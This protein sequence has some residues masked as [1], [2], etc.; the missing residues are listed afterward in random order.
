MRNSARWKTSWLISRLAAS[1]R[2]SFRPADSSGW[3][4]FLQHGSSGGKRHLGHVAVAG[5]EGRTKETAFLQ[6]D[7]YPVYMQG[8]GKL[9]GDGFKQ[10]IAVEN[11]AHLFAQ[12]TE[13]PFGIIG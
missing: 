2:S 11:G 13:N 10:G 7:G 6:D 12:I 5:C 8:F 9:A 3:A 4:Q 1:W